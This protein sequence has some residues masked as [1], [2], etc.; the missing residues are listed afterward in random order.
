[1][2]HTL[3]DVA[4]ATLIRL[5]EVLG[6]TNMTC[7]FRNI[8]T[9]NYWL[10]KTDGKFKSKWQMHGPLTLPRQQRRMHEPLGDEVDGVTIVRGVPSA[11]RQAVL[12]GMSFTRREDI[13]GL[14]RIRILRADA[15]DAGGGF[16]AEQSVAAVIF[17]NYASGARIPDHAAETIRQFLPLAKQQIHALFPHPL[18]D[19]TSAWKLRSISL[20]LFREL[21]KCLVSADGA[22]FH[23]IYQMLARE[24]FRMIVPLDHRK[25]SEG[26]PDVTDSA[27]D[28]PASA[29]VDGA[30]EDSDSSF[31]GFDKTDDKPGENAATTSEAPA[32]PTDS[33]SRDRVA[34]SDSAG[35]PRNVLCTLSSVDAKNAVTLKGWWAEQ[36]LAINL[37]DK[38][39]VA[40]VSTAG[41]VF[42]ID[43]TR[44]YMTERQG[45]NREVAPEY[46]EWHPLTRSE[47][48]CP[49][50]VD[51]RVVGVINL[52]ASA[53]YAY[54]DEA[55]LVLYNFAALAAL[56]IR[57][58]TLWRDLTL[59]L[60]VTPD[61]LRAESKEEIYRQIKAQAVDLLLCDQDEVAIWDLE[62]GTWYPDPPSWDVDPR[63]EKDNDPG[64]TWQMVR[65]PRP[66]AI[67]LADVHPDTLH[68]DLQV[69]ELDEK[70]KLFKGWSSES[71]KLG[72]RKFNL[73]RKIA[74]PQGEVFSN[75][76]FPILGGQDNPNAVR[77]VL[78]VK[79]RRKF[80]CVLNDECWCL[81]LLCWRA[82]EALG[83][84]DKL[85]DREPDLRH[86]MFAY[87]F[88][89]RKARDWDHKYKREAAAKTETAVRPQYYENNLVVLHLDIRG[90]TSL[91]AELANA[92]Q[93]SSY[94]SLITEYYKIARGR[95]LEY[96]GVWDK[97]MGDGVHILFNVVLDQRLK[98]LRDGAASAVVAGVECAF[99]IMRDFHATALRLIKKYDM[100]R[101]TEGLCVAGGIAVGAGM[102][103]SFA[104][105]PFKGFDITAIGK[106]P[107]L[108]GKLMGEARTETVQQWLSECLARG[109]K[110]TT[111][112][113]QTYDANAAGQRVDMTVEAIEELIQLLE[114]Q[115]QNGIGVL[116][117]DGRASTT[118]GIGPL[119]SQR[120]YKCFALPRPKGRA[121]T[122]SVIP[123]LI[124]PRSDGTAEKPTVTAQVSRAVRARR[125][126]RPGAESER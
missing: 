105:E 69:S 97:T 94:A 56:V 14:I 61:L 76:G 74:N 6:A 29:A 33:S 32:N 113:A 70:S 104:E 39:I 122:E 117:G 95:A 44:K 15:E 78:W 3:K 4:C 68:F 84:A 107:N 35:E 121:D 9:G 98:V 8:Y 109:N 5:R 110:G 75:L 102:V 1:M 96:G 91:S 2:D 73:N 21:Q 45:V 34:H 106:A 42:R 59:S 60:K 114:T 82:S 88:G 16:G 54:D 22:Q 83:V 38:G 24:A 72:F 92:N 118:S 111:N 62:D 116:L 25:R 58:E 93:Q 71:E 7:Y 36:E 40:H 89:D 77:A 112:C 11:L 47:L 18:I 101:S 108:A 10:L 80:L 46:Q 48:A 119:L 53:P 37:K 43:D 85:R 125:R 31:E 66:I 19:P 28:A 67:A 52:E 87:H 49:I 50:I 100:T 86:K 90:S 65:H 63:D 23:Q 126:N 17:F 57:Q 55:V 124:V 120:G 115:R 20:A 12:S 41:Q 64:A 13:T 27:V 26:K 81:S 103:G 99:A 79:M 30:S 123:I 51:S